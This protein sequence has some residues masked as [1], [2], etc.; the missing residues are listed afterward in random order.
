M[1]RA[2]ARRDL[3]QR[4]HHARLQRAAPSETVGISMQCRAFRLTASINLRP[5]VHILFG[6][7]GAG[8]STL[9]SILAGVQ[10]A[11]AAVRPRRAITSSRFT[12]PRPRNFA[13]FRFSLVR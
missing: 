6:E 11:T 13:V 2:A 7:N 1:T 9:I 12:C 3:E 10:P 4:R 5:R 8:K